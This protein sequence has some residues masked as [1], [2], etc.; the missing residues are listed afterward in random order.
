MLRRARGLIL[1]ALISLA[2]FTA[3]LVVTQREEARRSRPRAA[4]PLPANT[5]ATARDWSH[6][7]KEGDRLKARITAKNFRQ[8]KA[9]AF[10]L[11]DGLE[12]RIYDE[13]M[14]TYDLVRTAQANFDTGTGSMYAEG[15]VEI[16]LDRKADGV[17][18]GQPAGR[19]LNIRSSGVTFDSKTMRISTERHATFEFDA[20]A[21]ESVGAVYD[22]GIGELTLSSAVHL[23]WRGSGQGEPMRLKAGHLVY[24]ESAS[25]IFL[26]PQASLRRGG[27]SLDAAD[28]VVILNEGSLQRVESIDGRGG[29]VAPGRELTYAAPRLAIDFGEAGA[30]RHIEGADG[31]QLISTSGSSSTRVTSNKIGLDFRIQERESMLEKAMATGK[32]RVESQPAAR[33][34]SP[35]PGPRILTS[36]VIEL[37]MRPNGQDIDQVETH[38]PGQIEFMP[39]RPSDKRRTVQG[40]RMNFT[41]ASGNAIE[42]FRCVQAST[43]TEGIGKDKKPVVTTTRSRDLQAWFDPKTGMMSR[44]EQ[45]TNFEYEEGTRQARSDRAILDQATEIITLRKSARVWDNSGSTTGDEIILDQTTG[46]MAAVGNVTSTRLPDSKP[47][48]NPSDTLVSSREPVHARASRMTTFDESRKIRYEGG[49][50]LWQGSTRITADTVLIDRDAERLEARGNVVTT[51]P[52]RRG[53]EPAQAGGAV[54]VVRAPRFDYDGKA[55]TGDYTG[56]SVMKRTNLDVTSNRLRAWFVE[57]PSKDG[58]TETVLDRMFADGA[59]EF[60]ERSPGRV[61]TGSSEH[62]EHYPREGRTVLIGGNPVVNDS[63]RGIT[64]GDAITWTAREDRLIVDNTGS[65]PAVSRIQRQKRN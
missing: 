17:A 42:T 34:G 53:G 30:I 44:L 32:A 35:P 21:G 13:S 41:Y 26:T 25:E 4:A 9:P 62:A 6:D 63:L 55:K 5:S 40:E 45:W 50:V 59:V 3:W 57:M 29:D 20:G 39:A 54:T 48:K 7:I 16:L 27:F 38:T 14:T 2:S 65:G 61:R 31:A 1:L 36:E 28:T 58:S 60:V 15:E 10:Y 19:L 51:T 8:V 56:G 11:L 12:M 52:D 47:S 33:A 22:P 43:R 46:Q 23:E 64:R 24:R 49:A 37:R 18:E